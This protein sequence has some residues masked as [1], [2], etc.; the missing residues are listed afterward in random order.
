MHVNVIQQL[1]HNLIK[2]IYT[3]EHSPDFRQEAGY[4]KIFCK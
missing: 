2:M 4:K 3:F 1:K